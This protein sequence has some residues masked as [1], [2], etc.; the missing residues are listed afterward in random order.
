MLYYNIMFSAIFFYLWT[1][2]H[3]L[4]AAEAIANVLTRLWLKLKKYV[5][6]DV[7]A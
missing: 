6:S 4:L 2:A 3:L 5:S 7:A 1:H